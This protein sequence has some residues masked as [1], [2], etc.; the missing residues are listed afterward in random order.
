MATEKRKNPFRVGGTVV[1]RYFTDRAV[2]LK[3]I[4]SALGEPGA[5]LLVYGPRR[6]GK[7]SAIESAVWRLRRKRQAAVIADLS[8]ATTVADM[9]SRILQG[10]TRQ[11]RSSWES[12]V[13]DLVNHLRVGVSIV[14]DTAAGHPTLVLDVGQRNAPLEEQRDTLA[15]ALDAIERLAEEKGRTIGIALDEFQEIHRFGGEEAEWHLRGVIQRHRHVSYVLAGSKESLIEAMTG[16][17]RA[18]FKLFELLPFGPIDGRHLARWIDSRL[19]S[20]GVR[21]QGAGRRIVELAQPR[22]RDIILLARSAFQIGARTGNLR[23]GDVWRALDQ[24]V[25]EED[26]LLRADWERRTALQQNVLRA[27]AAAEEKL[28]SEAAR[29]RFGLR[30]SAYV[31]AALDSLI[32]ADLVV[33]LGEG[34][35]EFDSP[36]M[37]RWVVRHALPDVGII[38]T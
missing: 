19:E 29:D 1:G 36:F 17:N 9:A 32:E 6:M 27:I 30:G 11:L 21:P 28:Y 22:T 14:L 15:E 25:D 24:V 4:G 34:R 37:R 5:K 35:Y 38:L 12:V 26:D 16:R 33:K 18:F 3:R 10:A 13:G 8:A 31:A 20:H 23:E 7:S 2:E